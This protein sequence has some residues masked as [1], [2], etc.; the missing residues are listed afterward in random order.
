MKI[1][2][3]TIF[4]TILVSI[5]SFVGIFALAIKREFLNKILLFLVSFAVGALF[6]DAFL[7]ILPESFEKLGIG[8][9]ASSLV[10]VGILVFFILE[11]FLRW[12][13]CH[14]P[15]S[16][17]HLHPVARLNLIGDSLHNFIDGMI[18]A[19]S[20]SVDI[21]IGITTTLAIILHEIPQE[22][23]DFGVLIYGGFLPKKALFF[24]FIAALFAILGAV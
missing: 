20:F 4:S 9:F 17:E 7:H 18:I 2:I 12:R 5:I 14:I 16:T 6:G 15:I 1:W 22:I 11:Q 10:I 23:G 24:N 3:Y 8:V 19:S 21:K 13:H